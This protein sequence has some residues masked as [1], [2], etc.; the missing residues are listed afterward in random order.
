MISTDRVGILRNR[1]MKYAAQLPPIILWRSNDGK[2]VLID[3]WNRLAAYAPLGVN[4]IPAVVVEEDLATALVAGL[5][6]NLPH[7]G[8]LRSGLDAH[9][10]LVVLAS[11]LGRRVTESEAVSVGL[12]H[13]PND[14]M[15]WYG[16]Q[17]FSVPQLPPYPTRDQKKQLKPAAKNNKQPARRAR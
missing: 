14:P 8:K 4:P 1:V 15:S 9:R 13:T 6:A 12:T 5:R 7:G 3:G 10:A 16:L 11:A 17:A 2:L